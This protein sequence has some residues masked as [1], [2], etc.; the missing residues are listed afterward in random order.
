MFLSLS[1]RK[2]QRNQSC[3]VIGA[4]QAR[5]ADYAARDRVRKA[6]RKRE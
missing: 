4:V 2:K 5:Q 3:M 6:D 1:Q